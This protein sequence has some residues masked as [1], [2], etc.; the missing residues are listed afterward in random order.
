MAGTRVQPEEAERGSGSKQ[1]CTESRTRAADGG[2]VAGS[3]A[4][5]TG[6]SP[7]PDLRAGL[8]GA[9]LP[10]CGRPGIHANGAAMESGGR[11][12]LLHHCPP[13]R[14]PC[15]A[16]VRVARTDIQPQNTV[17]KST[18]KRL[19]GKERVIAGLCAVWSPPRGT[20]GPRT[21]PRDGQTK[22]SRRQKASVSLSVTW[23]FRNRFLTPAPC[24]EVHA[25]LG[26]GACFPTTTGHGSYTTSRQ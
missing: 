6:H 3:P 14:T 24:R 25:A 13:C 18:C 16:S 7:P 10:P 4:H 17:R 9:G 11:R 23:S 22:P 12:K 20:W 21:Q 2:R 8:A 19:R 5:P 15:G 26:P 1:W